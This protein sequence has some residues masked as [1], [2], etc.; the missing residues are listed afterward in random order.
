M[1]LTPY[2]NQECSYQSVDTIQ[3]TGDKTYKSAVTVATRRVSKAK[4]EEAN[5]KEKII[6]VTEY[7]LEDIVPVLGD[8]IDGEEILAVEELVDFDGTIIGYRCFPRPPLGWFA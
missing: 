4:R 5:G 8:K 1:E 3:E 7:L 6:N 2:L